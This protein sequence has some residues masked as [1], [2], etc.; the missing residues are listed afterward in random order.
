MCKMSNDT[1]EF[2][3]C[4]DA[5]VRHVVSVVDSKTSQPGEVSFSFCSLP[6]LYSRVISLS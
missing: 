3:N 2:L 6:S 4:G 1:S 5:T